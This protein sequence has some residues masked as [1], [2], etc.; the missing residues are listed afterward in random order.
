MSVTRAIVRPAAK[1][2]AQ[3]PSSNARLLLTDPADYDQAITDALDL[4]RVDR[5][6]LRVVHYTVA[7]AGFRFVLLGT[8]AILATTGLNRWVDGASQLRDL[9]LDY[10]TANQNQRPLDR[11][12]WR[13]VR[14]P[15]LVVLELLA[16]SLSVGEVLRLEFVS[17]HVMHESDV[18]LTSVL[19]GDITA[20]ETLTA[21]KICQMT[22]RRY[23]QNTG[24]STFQ[25]ETVDRR[26]QSDIMA[27][28]AKELLT[29]YASIVGRAD[30]EVPGAAATKKMVIPTLHG[31][32]RMWI[33]DR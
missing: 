19:E 18:A 17:P 20:I 9:Y 24:S 10:S 26:S 14:E 21:A 8:G 6:N 2:I 22:A 13:V 1:S 11:T 33:R 28:R 29:A 31:R 15:S 3:D 4:F 25:N 5:A 7:T 27:A 16:D 30:G 32:G 23:V 12:Q